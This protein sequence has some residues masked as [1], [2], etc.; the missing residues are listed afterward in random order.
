MEH[1][2]GG[3]QLRI[4]YLIVG[5]GILSITMT[6]LIWTTLWVDKGAGPISNR[7]TTATW[8]GIR[9]ITGDKSRYLRLAGPIILVMTLVTWVLLMWIGWSFL[10]AGEADS[11]TDTMNGGS[12]TWY[13]RIYFTGYSMFT[14]GNGNYAPKEGFWQIISTLVSGS[15]M[16]FL[17]LGASYII[18]VVDAVVQK[19]AFATSITGVAEDPTTM[20]KDAWNGNDFNRMD[21]LLVNLSSDLSKLT[22]QHNAYP[23]LHYYYSE[24]TQQAGAI[25]IVLLDETLTMMEYG[26]SK[27]VHPNPVLQK[28]IRSGVATYLET[29]DFAMIASSDKIPPIPDLASLRETG[30]PVVPE[31]EFK[32]NVSSIE[33]RRKKLNGL[34]EANGRKWPM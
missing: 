15:G 28:S 11:I 34:I 9:K 14:L 3:T 26:V 31:E 23:L 19:R 17:T 5:I 22:Q 21:L 24:K 18:S 1:S 8:K 29:L 27:E 6:D 33:D 20:I 2:R 25:A 30:I 16:L 4:V 7:L 12:I 13:E 32:K 10:F